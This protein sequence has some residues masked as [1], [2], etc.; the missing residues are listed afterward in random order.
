MRSCQADLIDTTKGKIREESNCE[1]LEISR[2]Y[3]DAVTSRTVRN[4]ILAKNIFR[5]LCRVN[6]SYDG[7][8]DKGRYLKK[9]CL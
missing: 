1:K 5:I 8:K 3:I 9:K 2:L 4:N 7:M 6:T